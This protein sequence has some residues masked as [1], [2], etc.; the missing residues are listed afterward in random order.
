MNGEIDGCSRRLSQ[1][2]R[3]T[4][5]LLPKKKITT[6]CRRRRTKFR[7]AKRKHKKDKKYL[8]LQGVIF[9]AVLCGS[10]SYYDLGSKGSYTQIGPNS[11]YD[12]SEV[13]DFVDR[14]DFTFMGFQPRFLSE[15]D[16]CEAVEKTQK[17]LN[18]EADD[19][20]ISPEYP[21]DPFTE[22][23]L[24]SGS[25]IFHFVIML[26]MFLGLSIV[27]DDYFESSLEK[28]CESLNLKEDVAGATFMAAGGSAPELFTSI[29]G[30][31]VSKN[32]IGFG[33]I[34]GSAVFN[35]L[36][37]IAMCAFVV[38]NLKVTWWP[39]ARDCI[40][41]CIGIIALVGVVIDFKVYPV[42]AFFLLC[43]YAGYVTIMYYNE[44]LEE[45]TVM[46]VNKSI[47]ANKHM[48][49]LKKSLHKIVSSTPFDLV[50]YVAI[51]ANIVC[52]FYEGPL[53][54]ALNNICSALFIAE[55][56]I[57][58]FVYTFFGY[59][60]N[61]MNAFDGVLVVLIIFELAVTGGKDSVSGN[62]RAARLFRF[63]RA[64]RAVRVI[65]MWR[66][67][68][69]ETRDA[70]TQ[71]YEGDTIDLEGQKT[72]DANANYQRVT[73]Q[74]S[75]GAGAVVPVNGGQLETRPC[76]PAGEDDGGGNDDNDG[77][78]DDDDEDDDEDDDDEPIELFDYGETKLDNFLWAVKF[79]LCLC[80]F[81]TIPDVRRERFSEGH[82]FWVTFFMSIVWIALLAFVMVWMATIIGLI[83]GIPDP[84]MGLTLLAAGTSIPDALSSLAV[85]RKGFGDMAVSSSIGSN[86]FDILIG[87]PVP[88]FLATTVAG[89]KYVDINS[90]GLNIMVLMLFIMVGLV[91]VTIRA[92]GWVLTR[93]LAWMM[94]SLYCAFVAMSLLLEYCILM[95]CPT[96]AAA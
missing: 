11:D 55:A 20:C 57:K 35:V 82:W 27:C 4:Y 75:F 94:M 66:A 23:Q 59:W 47:E 90:D 67:F 42:E 1:G 49:P 80:M 26:W 29:M 53:P 30:V 50:I 87:L 15:E 95:T 92:S 85:A 71:T 63:V 6:S 51:T 52:V 48:P 78:D 39:L 68:Y 14:D 70:S 96:C 38:P 79:P 74:T 16:Q 60:N 32:D 37:V 10:M 13:Y 8:M 3:A 9:A 83:I 88:W 54:T 46:Q 61:P 62:L 7:L 76:E 18:C 36:F 2:P 31:F 45:W 93:K 5:S 17:Q 43:L 69:K 34:V 21:R 41:Y 22:S 25:L 72:L 86:V 40:S 89:R 56:V 65:K 28:I 58:I 19:H 64:L 81:F 84:V 77:D 24:R 73:P 33:T 91:I 12:N 44:R